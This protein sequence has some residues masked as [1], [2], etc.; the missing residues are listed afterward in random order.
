MSSKE[1]NSWMLKSF[2]S[3]ISTQYNSTVKILRS[4]NGSEFINSSV[5]DFFHFEGVIHQTTCVYTPQQ[6]GVVKRRH[7][8]ILEIARALRFEAAIPITFWG[9]CVL[10]VV[11]LINRIPSSFLENKSPYEIYFK[12]P[13]YLDHLKFFGCLA[14]AVSVDRKDKF[15]ARGLPVVFLGYSATQRGYKL[16][17]LHAKRVL[18]SRDVIFHESVFPFK[19]M[20]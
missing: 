17:D 11:H 3:M 20:S 13:F 18:F 9:D 7:R 4:N 8:Y 12:T 10:I 6:N 14:Y 15:V 19:P 16:Y 5:H 1:E 2:F